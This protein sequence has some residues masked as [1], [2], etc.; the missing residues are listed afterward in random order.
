MIWVFI[1][2]AIVVLVGSIIDLSINGW[3]ITK[4][5]FSDSYWGIFALIAGT[6]SAL[7]FYASSKSYRDTKINE[8]FLPNKRKINNLNNRST[9]MSTNKDY[10]TNE[11]DLSKLTM[12]SLVKKMAYE[13]TKP[14]PVFFKGWGNRRLELDVERVNIIKQY[15]ES[16]RDT[17]NSLMELQS[18]S[19]LSYE[20]IE[21]L[22]KIKRFDLQTK[23]LQAEKGLDFAKIEYED[24]IERLRLERASLE[25]DIKMKKVLREKIE[26]ENIILKLNAEADYKLM[27]AKSLRERQVALILAEAV[28]YFKELPSVLKSWVTVQLGNENAENPEKDMELEEQIKEFIIRKQEAETKKIEYDAE[29]H[30]AKKDTLKVKLE[31]ERTKYLDNGKV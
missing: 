29:E 22:T 7:M 3:E 4:Q 1:G 31:N 9:A 21:A 16:I 11:F 6:I 26:T 28:K 17:G 2:A 12:E 10:G 20:K 18:D 13:M 24:K 19:F 15:I 23:V 5:F 25:E 8:S 27:K 14:G 30:E